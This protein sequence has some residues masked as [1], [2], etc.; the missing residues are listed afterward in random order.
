MGLALL[1]EQNC[2]VEFRRPRG[3]L[4]LRDRKSKERVT[5]A[6]RLSALGHLPPSNIEIL[7]RFLF[8][9]RIAV[10]QRFRGR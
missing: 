8:W 5:V 10:F 9:I 3:L 7:S 1:G 2:K 4:I 6:D